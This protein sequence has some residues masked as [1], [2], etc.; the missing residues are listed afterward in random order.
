L[1]LKT[2]NKPNKKQ[3]HFGILWEERIDAF[4]NTPV[5]C[6]TFRRDHVI[7]KSHEE[8]TVEVEERVEEVLRQGQKEL[9]ETKTKHKRELAKVNMHLQMIFF[10]FFFF[11]S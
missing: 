11:N 10:E 8:K 2:T 5:S 4:D 3:C 6:S 9:Q 1:H 7:R